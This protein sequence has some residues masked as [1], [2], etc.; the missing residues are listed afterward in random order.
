MSLA[1]KLTVGIGAIV[2]VSGMALAPVKLARAA[3]LSVPQS[4]QSINERQNGMAYL[5][6]VQRQNNVDPKQ[7]AAYTKFFNTSA[8][9]PDKKIQLG[10]EFLKKYPT[11]P[12]SERVD[13]GLTNAYL[14]K[15]DWTNFYLY[16]NKAL[17]SNPDEIDVLTNVG[18]VIPHQY[19]ANAPGAAQQLQTAEADETHALDLLAKLPKP[20]HMSDQEFASMKAQKMQQAHS[21]LGLIYFRR[22][23]YT[24]S[25]SELQQST[26]AAASPDPTDL[27]VLGVDLQ[28]LN[29]HAD[30]AKAFERC[31][32][33]A[34]ALQDRCKDSASEESHQGGGH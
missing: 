29:R 26:Q 19:D 4:D 18:W 1:A 7:K 14:A 34:G 6:Q 21:A 28:N 3:Q 22:A 17:A 13:V 8:Q 16:A 25:A 27:F 12:F 9:E 5:T 15:Q 30:A 23:D 10:T 24:K 32:Q 2:L 33:I 20:K 11:S 31:S